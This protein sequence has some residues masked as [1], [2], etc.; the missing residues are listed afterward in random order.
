M[1]VLAHNYNNALEGYDAYKK[2]LAVKRHFTSN[3]Y[4][5][6]EYEG[7]VS[8]TENSFLKRNDKYMF[9]KLQRKYGTGLDLISFL[10]SI[11]KDNPSTWVGGLLN[12][13]CHAKHLARTKTLS[14]FGYRF[15]QDIEL[16]FDELRV[17]DKQSFVSM[18][19]VSGDKTY[20]PIVEYWITGRIQPETIIVLNAYCDF[21]PYLDKQIG[22]QDSWVILRDNALKYEPFVMCGVNMNSAYEF[23][24][25]LMKQYNIS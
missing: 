5:F 24:D 19:T 14:G 8:C 13:E 7:V 9:V 15:K 10:V 1:T 22:E 20:P 17:T 3:D 23:L 2:Y 12:D 16:L 4:D 6:F 21:F 11:L 18:F 25:T